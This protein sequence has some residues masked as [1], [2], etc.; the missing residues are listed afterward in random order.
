MNAQSIA[1]KK[2]KEAKKKERN[3]ETKFP[4]ETNLF[5]SLQNYVSLYATLECF[6][7]AIAALSLFGPSKRID[8]TVILCYTAGVISHLFTHQQATYIQV[9]ADTTTN[10]VNL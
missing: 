4:F 8:N 9:V 6:A 7:I 2:K 5:T 1:K 3:C 10:T